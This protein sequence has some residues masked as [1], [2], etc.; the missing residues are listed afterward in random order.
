[1][2]AENIKGIKAVD[3]TA[4]A[5]NV[6]RITGANEQG[7]TSVLDAIT[8]AIGG[9]NCIPPDPIRHGAKE[10]HIT[11]DCGEFIVERRWT[12][13]ED[14]SKTYL[15][16][17]ARDGKKY[18][19]PQALLNSWIGS[20]SFDPLEFAGMEAKKQMEELAKLIKLDIDLDE[21]EVQQKGIYDERTIVNRRIR[22]L[23][24]QL[25]GMEKPKDDLPAEPISIT[26]LTD[27]LNEALDT[28]RSN[29]GKRRQLEKLRDEREKVTEKIHAKK[30]EIERLQSELTVLEAE[31]AGIDNRGIALKKEVENLNDPD[32]ATLRE[33]IKNAESTNQR[34]REA[35]IYREKVKVFKAEEAASEDLSGQLQANARRKREAIQKAQYPIEGLSLSDEYV[36]YRGIPFEQLSGAE[37]LKV[38]M[39]VAMAVNPKLRVIRIKDGSL[40]DSKNLAIIDQMAGENN[41]QIW[42]ESVDESGEI[43]IVIEAGEVKTNN[44]NKAMG[45]SESESVLE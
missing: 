2:E 27:Q 34:I 22:E 20:L 44:Y 6:I 28:V 10:A 33:A 23:E 14:L 29:E 41:F 5:V 39:A 9:A 42:M 19:S 45:K 36:T 17:K 43:G 32:T 16:V 11:L 8:M 3:I 4:P 30:R 38:S 25:K 18:A 37:T 12:E 21:W 24:G 31:K 1:L 15:T 35:R 26:L 7:K 40:L 13:P